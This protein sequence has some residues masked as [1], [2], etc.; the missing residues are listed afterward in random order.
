[1]NETQSESL[2]K[3]VES[4]QPTGIARR[5]LLRAGLAAGPVVLALSGRS[6]LACTTNPPQGLSAAAW[7]SFQ[8][9]G[10]CASKSLSVPV[11]TYALC[12]PPHV[13]NPCSNPSCV[14]SWPIQYCTPFYQ[15]RKKTTGHIYRYQIPS[16]NT[17]EIDAN[18]SDGWGT[19]T[20]CYQALGCGPS[21]AMSRILHDDPASLEAYICAAY[22]NYRTNT[23]YALSKQDIKDVY[24]GK[25]GSKTNCS[26]DECKRF[27]A[28]TMKS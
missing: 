9:N 1:M 14:T 13:W 28:Q 4:V 2:P 10:G 16:C 7:A 8:A 3:P 24:F 22:L 12:D 20:T 19:G 18:D 5:R 15:I 17:N 11:Q 6:A 26:V 23:N 25:I 27:L 21:K